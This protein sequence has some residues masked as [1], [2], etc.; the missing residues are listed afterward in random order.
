MNFI[1]ETSGRISNLEV[2]NPLGGGCT[3]EAI[4]L[5]KQVHWSPGI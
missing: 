2:V 1:V 5:L 4:V 3:E